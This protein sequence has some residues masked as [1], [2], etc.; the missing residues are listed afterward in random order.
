MT[1]STICFSFRS[2]HLKKISFRIFDIFK[3][4]GVRHISIDI[5][6][7]LFLDLSENVSCFWLDFDG[8][9]ETGCIV[10]GRGEG[11]A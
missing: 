3:I 8:Q 10:E 2:E 11:E 5:N 9:V 1:E 4:L 6:G 7:F